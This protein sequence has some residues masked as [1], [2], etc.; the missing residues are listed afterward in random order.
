MTRTQEKNNKDTVNHQQHD[1][2]ANGCVQTMG[3]IRYIHVR[4]C[5]CWNAASPRYWGFSMF[6]PPQANL[7]HTVHI[8]A[9]M[10]TCYCSILFYW[11][12]CLV[13][14]SVHQ[15]LG[16][17]QRIVVHPTILGKNMCESLPQLEMVITLEGI[18]TVFETIYT[19]D[20]WMYHDVSVIHP[21]Y[22]HLANL[23]L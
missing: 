5:K 22:P 12:W 4:S 21:M 2:I 3:Y 17:C 10:I 16:N 8:C 18:K 11:S 19:G 1:P 15:R 6:F 13:V 20:Q 7:E 23:C 14:I 9:Y